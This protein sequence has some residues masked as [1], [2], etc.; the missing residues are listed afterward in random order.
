[1]AINQVN[2]YLVSY[3]ISEPK[4]LQRIH[5]VLKKQGLP[6]QYS[7]FSV[8]LTKARL[9]SLIEMLKYIIDEREDDIRCYS[10]PASINCSVLGQQF[11]PDDV[12]LFSQGVNRLIVMN[13]M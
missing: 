7:V 9:L 1:M 13:S 6:I 8:V 11:F 5:R 3:D 10:L 12:L 2:Q 4:R